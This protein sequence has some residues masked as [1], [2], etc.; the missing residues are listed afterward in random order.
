M[1]L[2]NYQNNNNNKHEKVNVYL[3]LKPKQ[4]NNSNNENETFLTGNSIEED[5]DCIKLLSNNI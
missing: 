1:T 5:Q 4:Y 3:R 2:D